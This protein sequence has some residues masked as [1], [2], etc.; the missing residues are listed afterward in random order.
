MILLVKLQRLKKNKGLIKYLKNTGWMITEQ[1]LRIISGLF[2]GVWV[3][4]YLGPERFGLFSYVLALTAIFG[5]IAKLGLDTIVVRELVYYPEKRDTYLGTA[6]WLKFIA[7]F[8]IIALVIAIAPYITKD[9]QS[10][11]FILIIAGG[12]IFQ[13]FQV[14]EFYFQSQVEA[15]IVSI[16]KVIQL[17]LSTAIKVYLV[18]IKAKLVYF[19]MATTFDSFSLAVS[20]FIAYATNQKRSFYKCFDLKV[21]K[22]L[23]KDSWPLIFSMLFI[24]LYMK[25]DQVMIGKILGVQEVGIYTAGIKF[26]EFTLFLPTIIITSL[27]PAILSSKEKGGTIYENRLQYLYSMMIYMSLPFL[28]IFHF[29]SDYIINFTF[30]EQ[31]S[32]SSNVLSLYC[33]ALPFMYL[34]I[35]NS[36]WFVAENLQSLLF[37][38]AMSGAIINIVLNLTLIPLIGVNGAV[39]STIISYVFI[40]FIFDFFNSKTR[41][42]ATI[43]LKSVFLSGIVRRL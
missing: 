31:Y 39:I 21:A 41:H 5:G 34:A 10:N 15:K 24:M 35:A 1:I 13:S 37:Y 38:R 43:K 4:R 29:Y 14:V 22:Q 17:A 42:M 11:L 6:F 28:M 32:L 9:S 27:F 30:S 26:V 12:L 40:A 23:I 20:Y 16:C 7:S 36:R 3:A 18:L 33:F 25:I 2:V 19:V 8:A